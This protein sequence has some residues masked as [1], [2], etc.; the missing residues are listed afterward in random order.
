[1]LVAPALYGGRGLGMDEYNWAEYESEVTDAILT[2][3]KDNVKVGEGLYDFANIGV[4]EY[5]TVDELAHVISTV[6]VDTDTV[7]GKPSG[8]WY[9]NSKKACDMVAYHIGALIDVCDDTG[10]DLRTA[11]LD[12]WEWCDVMCRV[13]LVPQIAGEVAENIVWEIETETDIDIDD[14]IESFNMATEVWE[15]PDRYVIERKE[16]E[17]PSQVTFDAD[18]E[19]TI[20]KK[21]AENLGHI[22]EVR[23]G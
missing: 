3:F 6:C 4:D 19:L 18:D 15:G 10:E 11:L 23:V 22:E 12:G 2:W 13:W 1:M 9:C 14:Y 16:G 7:T 17:W 21:V 20:V 8:S 5:K